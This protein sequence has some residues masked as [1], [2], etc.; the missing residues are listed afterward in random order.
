ML[1]AHFEKR[2]AIILAV[3]LHPLIHQALDGFQ[4]RI[5]EEPRLLLARKQSRRTRLLQRLAYDRMGRLT[6]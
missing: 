1:P 2:G 5:T 4:P 3:A 6:D